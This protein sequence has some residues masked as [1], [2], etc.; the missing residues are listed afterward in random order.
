MQLVNLFENHAHA[1]SAL[2]LAL[3]ENATKML[4]QI[5]VPEQHQGQTLTR[6]DPN[7]LHVTLIS[8]RNFKNVPNKQDYENTGISAPSIV[9]DKTAFVYRPGK[10]TYVLSLKNQNELKEFVDKIY[11]E[12]NQKNPEPDRFFHITLANNMGGDP[13]KSIGDV[14]K[15][16]T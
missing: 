7:R 16:D 8:F 13:F 6:L 1:E 2:L 12:N 9:P 11:A 5:Q 14:K 4:Q 10:I 3:D 15:E